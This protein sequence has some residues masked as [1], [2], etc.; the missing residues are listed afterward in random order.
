MGR[1]SAGAPA[2]EI[3]H[4]HRLFG[5]VDLR[6]IVHAMATPSCSITSALVGLHMPTSSVHPPPHPPPTYIPLASPCPQ[7]SEGVFVPLTV[8]GGIREFTDGTGKHYSALQVA[9]EYFRC[10]SSL[11]GDCYEMWARH[12]RRRALTA[13]ST[14]RWGVPCLARRFT[15]SDTSAPLFDS[16]RNVPTPGP[17]TRA[18][19]SGADKVSI[20]S[21]AVE[22]VEQYLARDKQKDG[23]TAIEQISRV[24][25]AQ[26]TTASSACVAVGSCGSDAP[27]PDPR[28]HTSAT[29]P[30]CLTS[31]LQAV[32]VS[33]DPKRVWVADP[34]TTT[35]H[36]VKSSKTGEGRKG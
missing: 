17:P 16:M 25:G 5:S 13:S 24:Y 34:A 35:H 30:L 31:L 28:P 10:G 36:C 27:A 1:A 9:A 7:A 15:L 6:L 18:C 3:V 11:C 14:K 23:S 29:C 21:D 19:R 22:A 26:V 4:K 8:G 32:V 12:S 20:G 2:Q 33:I